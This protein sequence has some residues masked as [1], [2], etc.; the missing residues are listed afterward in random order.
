MVMPRTPVL[1]CYIQSSYKSV[2][3]PMRHGSPRGCCRRQR[4]RQRPPY[5]AI[6]SPAPPSPRTTGSLCYISR[7]PKHSIYVERA[8]AL[9]LL[10]GKRPALVNLWAFP[11][12]H[13][14]PLA[15][16]ALRSDRRMDVFKC[17]ESRA[18]SVSLLPS[19]CCLICRVW[20]QPGLCRRQQNALP[21][22]SDPMAACMAQLRACAGG[23]VAISVHWDATG[24]LC[25]RSLALSIGFDFSAAWL[26]LGRD[27][28]AP[29]RLE[30]AAS[31]RPTDGA[32]LPTHP[33]CC[34]RPPQL[35]AHSA[36]RRLRRPAP[37]AAM[38]CSPP[39]SF[40]WCVDVPSCHMA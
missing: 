24:C 18:A 13:S 33:V 31:A 14:R 37:M 40:A 26:W 28:A 7:L 20:G 12:A 5:N 25:P 38:I 6:P 9:W 34:A 32:P 30:E 21:T 36:T 29:R 22:A 8:A 16:S 39:T 15:A 2:K 4:P 35:P 10:E 3:G 23:G 17:E 27:P 19:E 1:A 11:L